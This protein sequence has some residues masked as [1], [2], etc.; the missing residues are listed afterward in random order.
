MSFTSP[1]EK[2][3]WLSALAVLLAIYATVGIAQPVGSW[4]SGRGL[5]EAAFLSG[6]VLTAATVLCLA[7][8]KKPSGLVLGL[9][10]GIVA[11]YFM[12]LV[13][14]EIPQ[15]RTHLIEYG[16]LA[17]VVYQALAE[18]KR[19]LQQLRGIAW[20]A[21]AAATLAGLLDECLQLL[22][23]GRVFDWRD[24]L[25]NFLASGMAVGATLLLQRARA[26]RM[27][28]KREK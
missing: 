3:L 26:W 25:F 13:R 19:H 9:G 12:V 7:L 15:E 22:V 4:L 27:N 8:Q 20:L 10:L 21:I 17:A 2:R 23:P 5:L 1:R 6:M 14:I 18:R 28:R 16:V 24:L 11:V